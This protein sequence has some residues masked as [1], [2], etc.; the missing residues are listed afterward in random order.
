[1]NNNLCIILF[2]ISLKNHLKFGLHFKSQPR[3][4]PSQMKTKK[5]F[6]LFRN[7]DKTIA[8][9]GHF[10]RCIDVIRHG[11]NFLKNI[12]GTKDPVNNTSTHADL[13]ICRKN[14][15]LRLE[16]DSTT[17]LHSRAHTHTHTAT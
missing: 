4:F 11:S 17:F 8:F 1:M 3:L 9:G 12:L 13:W 2:T 15:V 14:I 6:S 5:N 10:H 16:E 7:A